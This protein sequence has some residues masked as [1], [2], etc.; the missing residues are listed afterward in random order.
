MDSGRVRLSRSIVGEEE[1]REV[2]RVLIED[3]YLGMGSEV[4][5]FEGEIAAF[6]GVPRDHVA[7]VASGTSALQLA[8]EAV[9]D[10]P[11]D[12]LVPSLTFVSSF[13]AIRAARCT[14]VSCDSREGDALLDLEDVARRVTPGANV[15]MP[16]HYASWPGDPEAVYAFARERGLRVVEDAAH[17]FGCTVGGKRVGSFGDVVCFS[18]DGIKNITSGEGGAVV[19]AD[20]EVMRRVRDARLL[21]VEKDTDARFSGARSWEFEVSRQGYRSHMSNLFAAVG[22]VQLRRFTA[23]AEARIA[24]ARQYRTRLAGLGGI[25]FFETDLGPVVPHIQPVRVLGGRRDE[26]RARLLA[27]GIETGIHYKPNH[28]LALFGG[29]APRLPVAER[30]YGELLSLPLHPGLRAEDVD[31]VCGAIIET[32]G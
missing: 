2:A 8:V 30:L 28:L 11:A 27:A 24:L 15:L 25:A 31:R 16:V 5:R 7:C 9:V 10:E 32:L 13:Q 3:G 23:F 19:S 26:V 29:G 17:S 6:L 21:G 18:F 1:A 4:D 20:P 14:P 12:V 22:R